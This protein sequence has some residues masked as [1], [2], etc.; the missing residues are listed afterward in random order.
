MSNDIYYVYAY[1]RKSDGTPYYIG[2]GRLNRAFCSHGKLSVPKDKSKIVFL[3]T[4]LTE[5]GALALER[6]YIRWWGRKDLG[7]GIL[8]NKTDGGEGSSGLIMS[9]VAKLKLSEY[10]SGKKL[11]EETKQKISKYRKGKPSGTSGKKLSE[12]TKR[13]MSES[14]KGRIFSEEHKR[15]ISEAKRN[16]LTKE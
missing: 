10:H 7:T 11:S 13:K 3:E 16:K 2:K 14:Q 1:I 5:L 9:D 8:L 12:E 15:K 6:R 4:N